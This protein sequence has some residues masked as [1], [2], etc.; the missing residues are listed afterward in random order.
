MKKAPLIV[1]TILFIAAVV[2]AIVFF[3]QSS[4]RKSQLTAQQ[5]KAAELEK[6][7]DDLKRQ[8]TAAKQALIDAEASLKEAQ[9]GCESERKQWQTRLENQQKSYAEAARRLNDCTTELSRANATL[10]SLEQKGK[11]CAQTAQTCAAMLEQAHSE[12]Q[13]LL[14]EKEGLKTRLETLRQKADRAD[15]CSADLKQT[16]AALKSIEQKEK[17]WAQ[18]AQTCAAMLEQ[19]HSEIQHLIAEKE[20]F[21]TRFE[22]LR[23]KA[24]QAQTCAERLADASKELN[25]LKKVQEELRQLTATRHAHLEAARQKIDQL[26]SQNR[27]LE[28]RF[29]AAHAKAAENDACSA[30]LAD[31]YQQ[32]TAIRQTENKARENART[33][34]FRLSQ[35]Q[36]KI[37]RLLSENKTLTEQLT[38]LKARS[39]ENDACTAE[40]AEV[41]QQLLALTQAEKNARENARTSA[42]RLSEIQNEIDRLLS[43]NKT[44]Q[45]ELD[46]LREQA[47]QMEDCGRQLRVVQN[48]LTKI[49]QS[50]N[51]TRQKLAAT[52]YR[53]E[54]VQ[55]EATR[56]VN[57][58][59]YLENQL[60]ACGAAL[61]ALTDE[62]DLLEGEKEH[63]ARRAR[64]LEDA[65][66]K[67]RVALRSE[68]ENKEAVIQQIRKKLRVTFVGKILF[69]FGEARITPEGRRQLRKVAPI[70]AQVEDS[71]IRVVGHTDDVPI[72][73]DHPDRF[74]SNWEL[75]AARA[76]AVVRFLI[77]QGRMSPVNLEAVGRSFFDP[78]ADNKTDAGRAQNRRVELVIM[79][80]NPGR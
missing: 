19:A 1:V 18:T 78:V 42:A 79:P 26:L 20:G 23:Q 36:N 73:P 21:K 56:L 11:K 80:F 29:Q 51:D 77:E 40:L 8:L 17:Q 24:D 2:A 72:S 61:K 50:E 76:S 3:Q 52:A 44:L 4:Q 63:A 71:T 65:Y 46:A 69:E 9:S 5:E 60:S 33:S 32:L 49:Q 43:E 55:D 34:A 25:A 59:H 75:S 16:N 30:E 66:Q 54:Q 57:E 22:T 27:E 38:A 14:A 47:S 10:D 37:D 39:R 13:H 7:A 45:Q 6:A 70:L 15:A 64:Q 28:Q 62:M 74:P 53:L 67:L 48:R 68:I 12:I 58:N 31:A 35:A 41:R